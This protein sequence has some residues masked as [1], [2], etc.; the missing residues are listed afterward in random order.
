MHYSFVTIGGALI[1]ICASVANAQEPEDPPAS[2]PTAPTPSEAAPIAPVAPV[3]PVD[4]LEKSAKADKRD[5]KKKRK[6]LELGGRVLARG[7]TTKS[8]GEPDWLGRSTIDSARARADYRAHGL[9]AQLSVELAGKPRLKNAFIQVRVYDAMPKLDVRAGQFKMP[10]S[11][12]ELESRLALPMADRGLLHTVLVNRLQVA[13]RSVGAM[14]SLALKHAGDARLDAG[15]FQAFDDAGNSLEVSARDR[16]GQDAV[17]RISAEPVHGVAVGASGQARVGALN[18]DVPLIIR[19]GYAGEVD[20]T[21]E[22]STG[23]GTVRAWLEG[24]VGTSWIS[25]RLMPCS[26]MKSCKAAFVEARSIAAYR[27]GGRARRDRYVELYGLAGAMDPDRDATNDRVLEVSGGLTYGAWDLW[28]VQ[29][30]AEAWRFGDNAPLGIAEFA[31][32]PVSS[33]RFLVQL[34]AR[35]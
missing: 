31:S 5:D 16:F 3:E 9:H 24:M 8:D 27:L 34:G 18:I 14:M 28:R 22:A 10:F 33:T 19:R 11:Q 4:K 30:E 2:E 12:I 15:V 13:G 7:A 20:A 21:V 17:V 25:G 35:L 23:P 1:L 29:A 26:G 32:A 6:K